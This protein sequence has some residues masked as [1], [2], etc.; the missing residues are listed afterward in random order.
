MF[1]I[2]LLY[3]H[4]RCGVLVVFGRI[5]EGLVV[6]KVLHKKHALCQDLLEKGAEKIK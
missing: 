3:I 2:C 5:G 6:F 4:G 1:L